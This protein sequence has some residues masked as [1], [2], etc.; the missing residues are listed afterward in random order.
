MPA[1]VVFVLHERVREDLAL[2]R[3]GRAA[4]EVAGHTVATCRQA[5][6][7][8]GGDG[9]AVEGSRL[10]VTFGGDGTFLR[11]A[12]AA[13]PVGVPLLGVNL[14]RLGFLTWV[15]LE[16]APLALTAWTR[17]ELLPEARP[18]LTVSVGSAS[19]RVV[20]NEAALLK[21]ADA[22]VIQVDLAVDGEAAGVFHADGALLASPT[23]STAYSASA[24]GPLLDPRVDGM[25]F[26]PLNPHTLASRALVLPGGSRAE[27]RATE[28]TRVILDGAE[29][30]DLA[31]GTALNCALDGPA[32]KL[33]RGTS[34]PGFYRQLRAKMGWGL[35]LVDRGGRGG[36]E[37]AG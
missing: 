31:A 11:A 28:A 3:A 27:L 26:I 8:A 17:G 23:G 18:T 32:M 30:L 14:G 15:D 4:V 34:S 36:E 1:D 37:P 25:V 22:N 16:D 6:S 2:V 7:R 12:R 21:L 19:T 29:S 5:C 20:V 10:V 9:L 33:L 24:G 13:V 35:P